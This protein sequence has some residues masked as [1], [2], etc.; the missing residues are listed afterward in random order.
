MYVLVNPCTLILYHG[1]LISDRSVQISGPQEIPRESM[2]LAAKCA[3][4][5]NVALAFFTLKIDVS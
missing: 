2:I 5:H 3:H 1:V 4:A